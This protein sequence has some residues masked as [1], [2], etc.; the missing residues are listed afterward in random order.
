[1]VGQILRG[2]EKVALNV[3]RSA[4]MEKEVWE[5]HGYVHGRPDRAPLPV[6]GNVNALLLHQAGK[7]GIPGGS[8]A[9]AGA[10][11]VDV[12]WGDLDGD[13]LVA[14]L[15]PPEVDGGAL[16]Q[17]QL[18]QSLV[19]EPAPEDWAAARR[20]GDGA[21]RVDGGGAAICFQ[22]EGIEILTLGNKTSALTVAT[23]FP[24]LEVRLPP[25]H[26]HLFAGCFF[27]G[28]LLGIFVVVSLSFISRRGRNKNAD[29][30]SIAHVHSKWDLGADCPYLVVSLLKRKLGA[31]LEFGQSFL[32]RSFSH[33]FRFPHPL[34]G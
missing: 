1:M 30:E 5:T 23:D 7:G 20:G 28:V 21:E 13:L 3:Q 25:P 31:L 19:A 4:Q 2:K 22:K 10:D 24:G 11:G 8:R 33:H 18:H 16:Q 34:H 17:L 32:G 9:T 14:V 12:H 6:V 27:G 15:A 26:H 29:A